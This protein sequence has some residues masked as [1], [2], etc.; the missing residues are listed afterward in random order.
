MQLQLDGATRVHF[1]VGDP[2]A[3]VKS[4]AGV[5]EALQQRGHNAVVVPAHV[6]P[7]ALSGW[8]AG[9]SAAQNVDG[10]IVTVP[11]K[12]AAAS[13]CATLSRRAEFLQAANVMRR[14]ADGSWHGDMFDGLGYVEAMRAKGCDP[15]GQSALLVGAGGAGSAIAHA[16]VT[17]GVSRLVLHDES[18]ARRDTLV[19]RLAALGLCPVMAGAPD[20]AGV[21]I[22]LNATPMGMRAGDPLPFALEGLHAGTFVGCV[23]TAPAVPP[24]IEAARARGCKTSTGADMFAKVRDLMVDFLLGA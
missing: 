22:A 7:A 9:V 11:H 19:A 2:I 15:A 6:S 5:S 14:N 12:F 16:L 4:P 23:V 20:A 13:L 3:Q 18:A 24:V 17:S 10:I 8:L 1:I 21:D